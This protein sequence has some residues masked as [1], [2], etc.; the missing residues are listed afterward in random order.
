[1]LAPKGSG[2]L[3]IRKEAQKDVS[4]LLLAGGY[5]AYTAH[6]GTR[7]FPGMI[8]HG[9]A[10]EL[11]TAIGSE[12]VEQRILFLNEYCYDRLS[13]FDSIRLLR[14]KARELSSGLLSFSIEGHD[15]KAILESLRKRGLILRYVGKLKAIRVSTHIYNN[16]Q[17]IDRLVSAL[18]DEKVV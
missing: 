7:N 14:P 16:K 4:P 2:L 8:G 6:T 12:K 1:M 15:T 17:D 18:R 9:A 11:H 10:I 5:S 13:A 3:Y